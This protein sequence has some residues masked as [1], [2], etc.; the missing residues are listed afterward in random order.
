METDG[1]AFI[2]LGKPPV[3]SV[4]LDQHAGAGYNY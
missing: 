3:E 2:H 1:R 4:S